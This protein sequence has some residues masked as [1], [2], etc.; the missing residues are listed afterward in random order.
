MQE[1]RLGRAGP[2]DELQRALFHRMRR[3]IAA[4]AAPATNR[5]KPL[6]WRGA[7]RLRAC[8]RH[9][10]AC[11][12][13]EI[14]PV[15]RLHVLDGI[16]LQLAFGRKRAAVGM[17]GKQGFEKTFA[18]QRLGLA[19]CRWRVPGANRRSAWGVPRRGAPAAVSTSASSATN[20]GPKSESATPPTEVKSEPASISTWPP[21]S[22]AS[23]ATCSAG[24]RA[25]ALLHERRVQLGQPDLCRRIRRWR[26][27]PRKRA[28]RPSARSR[29]GRWSPACRS[30]K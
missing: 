23:R 3:Q 30:A 25:R 29:K 19:I 15:K 9:T 26:P 21:I 11:A 6:R 14:V 7:G 5:R 18:G 20:C 27:R 1:V 8:P 24:A 16:A 22:A 28:R 10:D 12:R 2:V 4:R 17:I 13:A